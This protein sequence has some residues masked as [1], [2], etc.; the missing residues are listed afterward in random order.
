MFDNRLQL[1]SNRSGRSP[2]RGG[3]KWL[4]SLLHPS[5][6]ASK[7]GQDLV[8]FA[9]IVP[10]L[11]LFIFGV[12]D[13]A[14][15]FHAMNVIYNAAREGARYVSQY[16]GINKVVVSGGTDYYELQPVEIQSVVRNE[17]GNLGLNLNVAGVVITVTC[18]THSPV[19]QCISGDK[20]RV[21]VNYPFQLILGQIINR[22]TLNISRT[23]EMVFP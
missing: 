3:V 15:V 14:R 12:I 2:L 7:P 20:V 19:S 23:A 21:V 18:P 5:R 22:S 4:S 13:F 16:G 10:I 8:E 9:L 1:A 6:V 11:I 17:A